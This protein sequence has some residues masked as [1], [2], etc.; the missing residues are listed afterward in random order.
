MHQDERYHLIMKFF[1]LCIL[2]ISTSAQASPDVL[3]CLGREEAYIH[4]NKIG[5][6]FKALNQAMIGELVLLG[7]S[8][9]IGPALQSQLCSPKTTFP[10]FLLLEK[11]LLTGSKTLNHRGDLTSTKDFSDQQTLKTLSQ[12]IFDIFIDFL[13]KLQAQ[14]DDPHCLTKKYPGLKEFYI[15]AQHVFE[16]QGAK[17]IL[18][19]FKRLPKLLEDIKSGKW[20]KNCEKKS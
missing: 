17:K 18:A 9:S 8:L 7:K 15:Q 4:K 6:A 10:S 12:N 3:K 5:G 1:A 2:V 16:E 14:V 11:T 13:T 19:D 20:K